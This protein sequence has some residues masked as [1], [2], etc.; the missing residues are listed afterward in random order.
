MLTA[1]LT[2][3]NLL[4]NRLYNIIYN[5]YTTIYVT[6]LLCPFNVEKIRA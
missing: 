2:F 5:F 3:V 4:C 1:Q 6:F